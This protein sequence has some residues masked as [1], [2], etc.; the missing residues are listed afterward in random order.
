MA[1]LIYVLCAVTST[2]CAVLLT[3][4]Y[5]RNRSRMLM[6]S[7]LGF[8][9]LAGNN[10]LLFVDALIVPSID[11]SLPRTATGLVGMALLVMGLIWEEQ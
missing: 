11:L 5:L 2:L 10:I 9:G 4:S 3:R 6:W 1:E 7:A 8:A